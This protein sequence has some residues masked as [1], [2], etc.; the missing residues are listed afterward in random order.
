MKPATASIR[1]MPVSTATHA[2][3]AWPDGNDGVTSRRTRESGTG[4]RRSKPHE[5]PTDGAAR[6]PHS[7]WMIAGTLRA[8]RSRGKG[9]DDM[10]PD[11]WRWRRHVEAVPARMALG[12]E[13][14]VGV[15]T[16]RQL[17]LA[18]VGLDHLADPVVPAQP[19]P[20]VTAL[21]GP[22]EGD[23]AAVVRGQLTPQTPVVGLDQIR[24]GGNSNQLDGTDDGQGL[25]LHL[26]CPRT[27]GF[28]HVPLTLLMCSAVVQ[29][30]RHNDR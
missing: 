23:V 28:R 4:S 21:R 19:P 18:R 30:H 29:V 14:V 12:Q 13:T 25:A 22:D 15:R 24:D 27:A 8:T 2:D 11:R 5:Q 1:P 10:A 6:V 7:R 3:A 16:L 9:P 17:G 26:L 20:P